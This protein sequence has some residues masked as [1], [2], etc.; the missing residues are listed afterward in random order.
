MSERR[1]NPGVS[2][3]VLTADD[4]HEASRFRLLAG[5]C[6]VQVTGPAEREYRGKVLV[7]WKPDDTVLVHDIEGYQPVA[8]ITRAETVSVDDSEA[9]ITAVDGDQWLRV[10]VRHRLD[11][12]HVPGSRA[13][14]PVSACPACRATLVD[15]G[16]EV[17][18]IDCGASYGLPRGAELIDQ[19]CDCGLPEMAVLR[20]ERF[21]L[22]I[23]RS[24]DPLQEAVADRYDGTWA[25]PD[26]ECGGDLRVIH[27]G[28]LMLACDTY[29]DCEVQFPF[30]DGR[31]EHT[32]EC[33]LP[34]FRVGD[35]VR[36]L[37]A[38]CPAD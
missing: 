34:R 4:G 11:D 28:G 3:D 13:G 25:C 1:T 2:S 31:L 17:H 23:D 33:G 7:L 18:C 37:D 20:G 6:R 38:D 24:C 27:R 12:R 21:D 5:D 35:T 32:C 19:H 22:C 26:A 14:P 10:D 8:W 15:A 9:I 16:G 30:P 36:C 29:P